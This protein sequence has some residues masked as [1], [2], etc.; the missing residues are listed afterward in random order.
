[1]EYGPALMLNPG[2]FDLRSRIMWAATN[3]L[4]NLTM[5]GRKSG[6]WG[7]HALGHTL[8]FLYDTPHG[9]SLSIM[10]PVWMKAM[11][12]RASKR[13]EF[14]GRELFGVSDVDQTSRAL[15]T[16]FSDLGSPVKCQEAGIELSQKEE[17]LQLM[18]QNKSGGIHYRLSD[19]ERKE[20]LDA[21][22]E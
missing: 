12:N 6:D 3:A 1:M 4:N 20:I 9:A 22:F 19:E 7:V 10:Y 21:T 13:I 15:K 8:S 11:E 17:I 18:N 2:D 5:Y 14:L 16:L